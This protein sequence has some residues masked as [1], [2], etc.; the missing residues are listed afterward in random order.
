MKL[1][2]DIEKGKKNAF[3]NLMMVSTLFKERKQY[4]IS[5]S[6]E[7][8][9]HSVKTKQD[10]L[11]RLL[12]SYITDRA[13]QLQDLFEVLSIAMEEKEN[14]SANAIAWLITKTFFLEYKV[15]LLD[16]ILDM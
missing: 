1:K 14:H 10:L 9:I 4:S 8:L 2:E 7:L 13:N 5:L 3:Q 6:R 15:V 16:C 12:L 11:C